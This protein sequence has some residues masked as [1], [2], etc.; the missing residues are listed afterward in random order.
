MEDVRT[1]FEW[2]RREIDQL[3]TV[4][5]GYTASKPFVTRVE[6]RP[7]DDVFKVTLELRTPLPPEVPHLVGNILTNTQGVLDYLA[8]NLCLDEGG[9]PNR[10]TYFPIVKKMN[11]DG[12]DPAVN[13]LGGEKNQQKNQI[14]DSR[15]LAL[16]RDIQ[17]YHFGQ[18]AELHKLAL[19]SEMNRK[20]K[21]RAPAVLISAVADAL[22]PYVP[23]GLNRQLGALPGQV[24]MISGQFNV[25]H[26]G[27]LMDMIPRDWVGKAELP[28]Y[29]HFLAI[30]SSADMPLGPESGEPLPILQILRDNCDFIELHLLKPLGVF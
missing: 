10:N 14:K 16:L 7:E 21:H 24:A 5:D 26:D 4:L 30:V 25:S 23:E 3:A 6:D 2:T 8:W 12:T 19:L 18:H 1:K 27:D 13:I 15:V 22:Y 9:K 20:A 29:D 17:P 11:A 28:I